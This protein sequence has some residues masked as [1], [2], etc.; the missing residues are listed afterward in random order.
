VDKEKDKFEKLTSDESAQVSDDAFTKA[1]NELDSIFKMIKL[2][3]DFLVKLQTPNQF[4]S[5]K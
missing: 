3:S 1:E 2:K 5:K 4:M